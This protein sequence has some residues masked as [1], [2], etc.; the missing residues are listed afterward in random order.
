MITGTPNSWDSTLSFT[1]NDNYNICTWSPCG[2]FIAAWA[3]RTVEIRNH[4]TLEL[5]AVFQS[6]EDA[7]CDCSSLAYSP[8]GWSLACGSSRS[9]VIRD[10]QTGGVA[11]EIKCDMKVVGLAWS[12]DGR[13]IAAT[14]KWASYL[15]IYD[16]A[17]GAGLSLEGPYYTSRCNLWAC[18]ESF[19]LGGALPTP[20]DDIFNISI[21][22]VGPPL[23]TT[24]TLQVTAYPPQRSSPAVAFSPSTHRVSILGSSTLRIFDS[25]TSDR[26]LEEHGRFISSTFSP[27]GSFFAASGD[28]DFRIWK[29]TSGSYLLWGKYQCWSLPS[30]YEEPPLRFSPTSSSILS[31]SRNVLQVRRLQDPPAPLHPHPQCAAISRSGRHIAIAHR[32]GST[33]VI[34]N[35]LLQTPSQFIDTCVEI[36]G[37]VITGNI[38]LVASSKEVLAYLLTDEGI[39]DGVFG[40][41]RASQSDSIWTMTSPLLRPEIM[42]LKVEGQVGVVWIDDVSPLIYHIETGDVLECYHEPQEV[43]RPWASL[44]TLSNFLEYY[45]PRYLDPPA[46][47]SPPPKDGWREAVWVTDPEGKHRFWVPFEWRGFWEPENW[48][49]DITT[50]FA[51]IGGQPLIIKF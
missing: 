22:H 50:L 19:R 34:A 20:S 44:R 17:S 25:Q 15:A 39:V 36:E 29:F 11:R 24:E 30:T 35:L 12:L 32:L 3:G 4:L 51:R 23:V 21:S 43:N 14:L 45:Y 16:V 46:D 31:W 8:D 5:L 18:G 33:V 41:R 26:L 42:S 13:T 27:D 9:I 28:A 40:N 47:N 37:L 49:Q 48:H 6:A 38:L 1:C 2:R 7:S 10:I